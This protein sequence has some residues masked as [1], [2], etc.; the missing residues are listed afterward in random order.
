MK[1]SVIGLSG[2]SMFFKLDHLP[3]VGETILTDKLHK[4]YGGKGFNQAV[5]LSKMG[6]DVSFLTKVGTDDSAEACEK[7]LFDNNVKKFGQ[8]QEGVTAIG[9]IYTSCEGDN[10]VIVYEGVSNHLQKEDVLEFEEEIKTSDY[11]L[12]QMETSLEV[13]KESIKLAKKHHTKV[14]LNAAPAKYLLSIEELDEIDIIVVNENEAK[15]LFM[16]P[17]NINISEYANFVYN[18]YKSTII[19]TLGKDGSMIVDNGKIYKIAAYKVRAVDTTGAGDTFIG[20]MTYALLN[21]KSIEKACDVASYG[22]SLAVT[23][24]YVLGAI[25]EKKIIDDILNK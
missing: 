19:I 4:E 13:L 3:N 9:V 1:V 5:V 20:L 24:P 10:E 18:K 7:V 14:V 22:S 16:I 8:R 17:D 6:V 23:K 25:P 2:L 11:L 12:V 21:N 15:T